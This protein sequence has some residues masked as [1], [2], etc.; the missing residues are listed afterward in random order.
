MKESIIY[1]CELCGFSSY[2][3]PAVSNCESQHE[4]IERIEEIIYYEQFKY[5]NKIRIRMIDGE[6]YTYKKE[7]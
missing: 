1:R 3:K 7:G 5:P 6:I 2:D 4:I